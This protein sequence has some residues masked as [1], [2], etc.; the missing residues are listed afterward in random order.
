MG[1]GA[2]SFGG[3]ERTAAG[4]ANAMLRP[5]VVRMAGWWWMLAL[6]VAA[7]YGLFGQG[8]SPNG[9]ARLAAGETFGVIHVSLRANYV[10]PELVT[11]EEGVYLIQIDD[12]FRVAAGVQAGVDTEAGQ[13]IRGKATDAR[14]PRTKMVVRLARGRHKIVLG[15]KNEWV[16]AVEVQ[17][18]KQ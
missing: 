14:S 2:P 4:K 16:V 1:S 9:D 7:G 5:G 18:K 17:A 10:L 11:V 13:R 15:T 8:T 3:S 12:P 6:T